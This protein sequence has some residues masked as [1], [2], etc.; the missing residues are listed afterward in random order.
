MQYAKINRVDYL[1]GM[2]APRG[3]RSFYKAEGVIVI[4]PDALPQLTEWSLQCRGETFTLKMVLPPYKSELG[5][6]TTFAKVKES[7]AMAS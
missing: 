5:I 7:R 3:K 4:S 6:V 2:P 1:P